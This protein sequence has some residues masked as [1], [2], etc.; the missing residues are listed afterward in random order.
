M[1]LVAL[2]SLTCGVIYL[3]VGD[4]TLGWIQAGGSALFVVVIG[5]YYLKIARHMR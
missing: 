3:L 5:W 1:L 4:S 2:S